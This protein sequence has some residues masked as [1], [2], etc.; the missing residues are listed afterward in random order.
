[1]IGVGE[2]IPVTEQFSIGQIMRPIFI[3]SEANESYSVRFIC[4]DPAQLN[5]PASRC[6][7]C[8][9]LLCKEIGS[10]DKLAYWRRLFTRRKFERTCLGNLP[11]QF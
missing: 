7:G 6:A 10:C 4:W 5:F 1:M 2:A 3:K 8:I 11:P 9:C